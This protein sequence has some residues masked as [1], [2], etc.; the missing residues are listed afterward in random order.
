M[1]IIIEF[2]TKETIFQSDDADLEI[3]DIMKKVTD[4]VYDGYL[5]GEV[6]SSNGNKIGYWT[7]DKGANK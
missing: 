1:K 2:S 5:E 7:I 3:G 6:N 4:L